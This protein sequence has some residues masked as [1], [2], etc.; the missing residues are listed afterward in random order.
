M[1]VL[2]WCADAVFAEAVMMVGAGALKL[3]RA[4]IMYAASP[5]GS[6]VC[7]YSLCLKHDG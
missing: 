5:R 2:E 4:L 7:F 1:A 6:W 3:L